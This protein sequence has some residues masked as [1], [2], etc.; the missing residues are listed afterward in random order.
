MNKTEFLIQKCHFKIE[1]CD[2]NYFDL[3]SKTILYKDDIF[4][5]NSVEK[6]LDTV[7]KYNDK[8]NNDFK[9]ELLEISDNTNELLDYNKL[10]LK[11]NNLI[12]AYNNPN[13]IL[14]GSLSLALQGTIYRKVFNK[15]KDLDFKTS[16][17]KVELLKIINSV[18]L[19]E[20]VYKIIDAGDNY[21]YC[22]SYN[23]YLLLDNGC[24]E[25]I[26]IDFYGSPEVQESRLING[27]YLGTASSIF[28]AKMK[29]YNNLGGREK[30]IKDFIS[31]K[32]W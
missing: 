7:L 20:K 3:Y 15:C 11:Y 25:K 21:Y 29:M 22:L 4:L 19:N 9:F 13:C 14:V 27:V 26:Q 18:Q 8:D 2:S 6:S 1:K 30:D 32:A 10:G 31:Y 12:S 28:K 17:S 5:N 23:H 24:Y 16:L